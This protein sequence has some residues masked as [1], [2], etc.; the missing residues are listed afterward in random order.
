MI[1]L[2]SILC[3]NIYI[4]QLHQVTSTTFFNYAIYQLIVC[5]DGTTYFHFFYGDKGK[6]HHYADK[7]IKGIGA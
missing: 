2:I 5:Y 7:L 3:C 4:V 6:F 1:T